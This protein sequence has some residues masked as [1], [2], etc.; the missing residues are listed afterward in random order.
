MIRKTPSKKRKRK[1]DLQKRKDNPSSR[2]WRIRADVEWAKRVKDRDARKCVIC[3]S[4][5]T[6]QAHH[7]I[8][9]YVWAYRFE[10]DNGISLCAYHHKYDLQ[11][12][13]HRGLIGFAE[14]LRVCR[15]EL[16]RAGVSRILEG[17]PSNPKKMDYKVAYERLC[18]GD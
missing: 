9:R 3:G 15:P 4:M 13:A 2:Y 6:V 8:S 7:L 18:H 10:I 17:F 12:S 11:C 5:T 14:K 16:W 1:S